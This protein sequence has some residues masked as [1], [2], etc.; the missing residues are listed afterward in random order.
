LLQLVLAQW[1]G[2]Q[3]PAGNRLRIELKKAKDQ[4]D[5]RDARGQ[6]GKALGRSLEGSGC[7]GA[8]SG[9]D[10]HS[11]HHAQELI[12]FPRGEKTDWGKKRIFFEDLFLGH[13]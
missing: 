12:T 10:G 3:G 13:R 11:S 8:T 9:R 5:I 1:V 4:R 2:W 7:G 6:K